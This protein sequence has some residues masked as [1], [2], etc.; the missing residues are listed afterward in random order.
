MNMP[1][2]SRTPNIT[3]SIAIGARSKDVAQRI[4]PLEAPENARSWLNVAEPKTIR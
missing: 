3:S 2:N 1:S 4:N